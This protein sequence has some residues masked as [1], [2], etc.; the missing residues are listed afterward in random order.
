MPR[1]VSSCPTLTGDPLPTP[2]L[3]LTTTDL[4]QK[5][6]TIPQNGSFLFLLISYSSQGGQHCRFPP[7]RWEGQHRGMVGTCSIDWE[8]TAVS[9][10]PGKDSRP[11][12]SP[13]SHGQGSCEVM[14][15]GQS[16]PGALLCN[17]AQFSGAS[18]GWLFHWDCHCFV[19]SCL[20]VPWVIK[21]PLSVSGLRAQKAVAAAYCPPRLWNWKTCW[22]LKLL[23]W[24]W[25]TG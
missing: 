15:W 7:R 8:Q 22:D 2:A 13:W 4:C 19:S 12:G 3:L 23:G 24:K 11:R 18:S 5:V 9:V 1:R 21:L 17:L 25:D 20:K 6:N 14:P 10:C 16:W